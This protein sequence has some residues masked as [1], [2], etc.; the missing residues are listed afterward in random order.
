LIFFNVIY[1]CYFCELD[2]IL[3]DMKN[4]YLRIVTLIA[5]TSI[6]F[7]QGIWMYSTYKPLEEDFKKT[8][9]ACFFIQ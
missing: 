2:K 5:L 9:V 4:K 3:Y 6:L 7:L 1:Y 8:S